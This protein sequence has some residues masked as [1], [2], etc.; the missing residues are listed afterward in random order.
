MSFRNQLSYFLTG[1]AVSRFIF[2]L[3]RDIEI[4]GI[5]FEPGV[6]SATIMPYLL[7]MEC[8]GNSKA[9]ALSIVASGI[10]AD[11][12]LY[13]LMRPGND[14]HAGVAAPFDTVIWVGSITLLVLF[15]TMYWIRTVTESPKQ[16]KSAP[17]YYGWLIFSCI[18]TVASF[19]I[20]YLATLYIPNEMRSTLVGGVEVHH[21]AI[22]AL[23]LVGLRTQH[24]WVRVLTSPWM[25]ILT[26]IAIGMI[27]DQSVFISL[28]HINDTS[29]NSLSSW[30]GAIVLTLVFCLAAFM[31]LRGK[32]E[33]TTVA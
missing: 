27:L 6:I 14:I 16:S 20:F 8:R 9:R 18:I 3:F 21:F 31:C 4:N 33:K 30:W 32:R 10:I 17:Y 23:V 24:S 19:R 7:L 28:I 26:G 22:G 5:I 12:L 29:Y 11:S 25:S 1:W 15:L 2:S 13:W